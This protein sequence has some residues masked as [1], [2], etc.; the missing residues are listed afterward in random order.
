MA[1]GLRACCRFEVANLLHDL[2][3]IGRFDIVLLRNVLLYFDPPTK[4]RVIETCTRQ[5]A[6]DGYLYLGATETLLGLRTRLVPVP[7]RRGVWRVGSP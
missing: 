1:P 4:E 7:G 3:H 2:S 5:L 6:P